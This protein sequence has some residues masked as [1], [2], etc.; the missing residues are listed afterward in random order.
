MSSP[1]DDVVAH[2]AEV[3]RS[4][5]FDD[6]RRRRVWQRRI[7]R[8]STEANSVHQ[9]AVAQVLAEWFWD[10]GEV[11]DAD[12][13]LPRRLKDPLSRALSGKA[14]LPARLKWAVIDAFDLDAET[15]TLL[16]DAPPAGQK[17]A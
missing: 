7:R 6:P 14:R 4:I 2:E 5:L 9:A 13:R 12:D 3:L 16:W 17:A 1:L 10:T 8:Q 15:A 11:S